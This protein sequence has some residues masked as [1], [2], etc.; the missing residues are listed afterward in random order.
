ME[1]A[2]VIILLYGFLCASVGAFGGFLIGRDYERLCGKA[3]EATGEP[4]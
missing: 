1:A 4:K 3:P 2:F